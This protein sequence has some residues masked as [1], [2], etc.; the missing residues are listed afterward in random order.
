MDNLV[1]ISSL[2][3]EYQRK[4]EKLERELKEKVNKYR[5]A[6]EALK[7]LPEY[8]GESSNIISDKGDRGNGARLT[9]NQKVKNIL[10]VR[11]CPQ[12][13]RDLMNAIN[14]TY[15]NKHYRFNGWSSAFSQMYTRDNSGIQKYEISNSTP[16]LTAFYGLSDWFNSNKE[17][18]DKY[19]DNLER[20][21]NIQKGLLIE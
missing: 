9:L 2:V 3:K 4:M 5:N 8:N 19:K 12:T 7:E 11:Q 6:I 14:E 13:S 21:Y 18:K 15:S 10:T 20:R 16:Q 17:L 1:S